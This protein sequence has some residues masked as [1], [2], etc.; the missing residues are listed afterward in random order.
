MPRYLGILGRRGR[1]EHSQRLRYCIC[2][3]QGRPFQGNTGG[4]FTLPLAIALQ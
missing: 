4:A 3:V 1:K 2:C